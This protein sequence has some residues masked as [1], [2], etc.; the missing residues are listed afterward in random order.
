[1]LKARFLLAERKGF[2]PLIDLHLYT[3]S[4]RAPSTTRTPLQR[5][6]SFQSVAS[7]CRTVKPELNS[8]PDHFFVDL[9]REP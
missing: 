6:S 9:R 1:M 3:L 2:E 8:G 5:N 4:R 7:A